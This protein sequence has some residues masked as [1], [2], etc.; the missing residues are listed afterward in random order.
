VKIIAR[1]NCDKLLVEMTE[2]EVANVTGKNDP[3]DLRIPTY[4]RQITGFETGTEYKVS[5][6]WDRLQ[7]QAK[8]AEQLEGVS[9]TLAALSD[10]VTQTKV[11]FTNATAT[12]ETNGGAA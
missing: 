6:A 12:T 7:R 8:A 2:Q 3:G 5:P 1:I 10:L 9:K 11:Q 4:V